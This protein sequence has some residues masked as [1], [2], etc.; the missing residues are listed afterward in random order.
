[1]TTPLPIYSYKPCSYTK[2]HHSTAISFDYHFQTH[3]M[4]PILIN[5]NLLLDSHDGRS[6]APIMHTYLWNGT[7]CVGSWAFTHPVY[8]CEWDLD[9][10]KVVMDPSA[11]WCWPHGKYIALLEPQLLTDHICLQGLTIKYKIPVTQHLASRL[12]LNYSVN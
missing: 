5:N 9:W 2:W 3:L 12:Y 8:F 11:C 1:M 4:M 6:T 10:V 7:K